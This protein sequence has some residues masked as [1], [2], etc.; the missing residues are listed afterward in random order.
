VAATGT[1]PGHSCPY[2]KTACHTQAKCPA[3]RRLPIR[4]DTPN[5]LR[6]EGETLFNGLRRVRPLTPVAIPQAPAGWQPAISPGPEP[7]LLLLEVGAPICAVPR[8]RPGGAK[9]L[10]LLCIGPLEGKEVVS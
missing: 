8:G 3:T 1:S 5:A 6:P 7:Q 2:T 10:G 9:R 4:H